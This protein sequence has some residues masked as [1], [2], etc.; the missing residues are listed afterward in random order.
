[1]MDRILWKF[2]DKDTFIAE[3]NQ[4]TNQTKLYEGPDGRFRDRLQLNQ[5][6]G[7]LT[8]RNISRAHSDVY[9]LKSQVAKRAHARDSWLLPM[10]SN[11]IIFMTAL[12]TLVL[13]L[14][15]K[16]ANKLEKSEQKYYVSK[17]SLLHQ[18]LGAFY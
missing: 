13:L 10:V 14:I 9:T 8:I 18:K 1:M 4:A 6:T 2:S 15:D 12:M 7:D 3:L 5:R 11:S 17:F 16:D